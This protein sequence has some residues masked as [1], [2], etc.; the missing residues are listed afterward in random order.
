MFEELRQNDYYFP[1]RADAGNPMGSRLT[2]HFV[3]TPTRADG[4]FSKE[5]YDELRKRPV[6]NEDTVREYDEVAAEA[7]DKN[8]EVHFGRI[9]DICVILKWMTNV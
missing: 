3:Q 5:Q 9:S 7:C 2:R 4:H 8:M 1:A 6:W